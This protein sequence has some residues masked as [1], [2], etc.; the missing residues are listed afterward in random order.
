MLSQ[1]WVE[2]SLNYNSYMI[3]PHVQKF[4]VVENSINEWSI[5]TGTW[6]NYSL[7]TCS[8][9][10]WILFFFFQDYWLTILYKLLVGSKVLN[11]TII[12]MKTKSTPENLRLYSHCTDIKRYHLITLI[13]DFVLHN[14]LQNIGSFPL[15]KM[16]KIHKFA[17]K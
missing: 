11:K 10:Y 6:D 16:P 7:S 4:K 2:P 1:S 9:T 13:C 17:T 5:L 14:I 8:Q 12:K 15:P 3:L